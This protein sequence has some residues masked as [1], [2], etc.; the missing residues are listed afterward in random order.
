MEYLS[1][2]QFLFVDFFYVGIMFYKKKLYAHHINGECLI[3]CSNLCKTRKEKVKCGSNVLKRYLEQS[4]REKSDMAKSCDKMWLHAQQRG[5]LSSIV[6]DKNS[7][8]QTVGQDWT[9]V[10]PSVFKLLSC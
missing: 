9:L 5:Y 6:T 10:T 4:A 1:W 7:I 3:K 2:P 8:Y